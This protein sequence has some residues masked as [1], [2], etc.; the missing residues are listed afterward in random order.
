MATCYFNASN[1]P[2][3]LSQPAFTTTLQTVTRKVAINKKVYINGVWQAQAYAYE[4]RP[5]IFRGADQ[6]TIAIGPILTPPVDFTWIYLPFSAPILLD[7]GEHYIGY[8]TTY[9][10]Q[11]GVYRAAMPTESIIH[12]VNGVTWT[13]YDKTYINAAPNYFPHPAYT[14]NTNSIEMGVDFRSVAPEMFVNVDGLWK[15]IDSMY[16]NINGV[17]KQADSLYININGT[18]KQS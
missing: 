13:I 4:L 1:S 5:V 9:I 11:V 17:W 2:S 14:D 7:A 16:A 3:A 18:W 10:M 8:S 12:V 15:P 6:A